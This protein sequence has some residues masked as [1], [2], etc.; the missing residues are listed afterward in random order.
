MTEKKKTNLKDVGEIYIVLHE[1]KCLIRHALLYQHNLKKIIAKG[2]WKGKDWNNKD[3][4][5]LGKLA[6]QCLD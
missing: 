4:M 6:E 3:Y 2:K 5:A 1:C